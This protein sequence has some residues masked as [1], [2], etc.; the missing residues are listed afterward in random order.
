M[1]G[2]PGYSQQARPTVASASVSGLGR[3]KARLQFGNAGFGGASRGPLPSPGGTLLGIRRQRIPASDLPEPQLPA[4]HL[5]VQPEHRTRQRAPAPLPHAPAAARRPRSRATVL[6]AADRSTRSSGRTASI[7]ARRWRR[8][9]RAWGPRL[10]STCS[11]MPPPGRSPALSAPP[12]ACRSC[13]CAWVRQSPRTRR[14]P[15]TSAASLR[16]DRPAD[17]PT[18]RRR[19]VPRNTPAGHPPRTGSPRAASRSQPTACRRNW[20]RVDPPPAGAVASWERCALPRGHAAGRVAANRSTGSIRT[21]PG[22]LRGSLDAPEP[23]PNGPDPQFAWD[24]VPAQG[25][26]SLHERPVPA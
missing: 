21:H 14:A 7:R 9:S 5:Q 1:R 10:P 22:N 11:A 17:R 3:G 23:N 15:R 2:P 8:R 19:A 26:S 13:G 25:P 24:F 20:D 12:R 4:F 16:R 18:R 6:A